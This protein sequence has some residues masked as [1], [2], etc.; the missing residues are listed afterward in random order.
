VIARIWRGATKLSDAEAYVEYVTKTGLA[1]YRKTPGN[2][3]AFVF[4]RQEGD[5]AEFMTVSLWD[6]IESIVKFA[7][8]DVGAAVFYPQ[9]DRYLISRDLSVTHYNA[10]T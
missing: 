5:R 2:Q 6:S 4:W 3:G 7:G 8:S 10:T 1:D 9:D